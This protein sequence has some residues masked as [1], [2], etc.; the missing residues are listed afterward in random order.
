MARLRRPDADGRRFLLAVLLVLASLPVARAQDND[1]PTIAIMETVAGVID[2]NAPEALYRFEARR[3]EH[4]SVLVHATGSGTLDP[5]V[6][7]I[8]PAGEVLAEADDISYPG[9]RDAAL[10]AVE[11]PRAG[12]YTVR[13][14]RFNSAQGRSAGP[15]VLALLPAYA[16]PVLWEDF[17]GDRPWMAGGS[18]M[19]I[20]VDDGRLVL[21]VDATNMLAWTAPGE[22]ITLPAR[23]YV[24]VEAAIANDPDY[25]EY[26]LVFRQS[27]PNDYYLFAVS[28]RG[29]WAFL[30]RSGPSAWEAVRDWTADDALADLAGGARLGVAMDGD[31]FTF[32]VAGVELATVTADAHDAPGGIG[33]SVGT[34]D[35][36]DAMPVITYDNLLVTEALPEPVVT[37]EAM[38]VPPLASWQAATSAPIL[39]ELAALELVPEGGS[40]VMLVPESF[41]SSSRAGMHDLALGQG[42]A[43]ADL[44]MGATVQIEDEGEGNA[45]GLIFRQENADRYS[46]AFVDALGG[47]GLATWQNEGFDPATYAQGYPD[48]D[49]LP[50]LLLVVQGEHAWL[51]LNGEMV[52]TQ[53]SESLAGGVGIVSLSYDNH[54]VNCTFLDTWL[55]TWE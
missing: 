38:T 49:V 18:P 51:F 55:W 39:E 9:Q 37:E 44:V 21:S 31:S 43:Q 25:W 33:L 40:Q 47:Y 8:D 36:Q 7:L 22:A 20:G 3:G 32:Y 28:S 54:F 11:M 41:T 34:A 19:T 27:G 35:R 6:Q 17:A 4:V 1:P 29:D 13:V 42:R 48:A 5:Y 15:Y 12:T 26:G 52:M 53:P 2:D 50:H 45:C 30:S 14:T 46:V 16:S 23:A 24:Q 10:E